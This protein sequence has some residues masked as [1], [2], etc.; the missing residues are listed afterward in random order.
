MTFKSFESIVKERYPSAEVFSH[1]AFAGSKINVTVIFKPN[2]R[3]YSYNGTYCSVL[4]RI[5]IKA[6]TKIDLWNY[7]LSL[8][9]LI[10]SDG[11]ESIF[12]DILDNTQEIERLKREIADY[13][14]NYIIVG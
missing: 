10:E 13:K 14:Q 4:N 6:I 11:K 1:G 9:H 5:G 12:G 7:E 2:G 3:C 8:N